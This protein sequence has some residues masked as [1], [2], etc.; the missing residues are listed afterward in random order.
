MLHKLGRRH[1]SRFGSQR[2]IL[3]ST[4]GDSPRSLSSHSPRSDYSQYTRLAWL[5]SADPSSAFSR[6]LADQQAVQQLEALRTMPAWLDD[7]LNPKVSALTSLQ[8]LTSFLSASWGFQIPNSYWNQAEH[9]NT[10]SRPGHK[11]SL[12][13]PVGS[14]SSRSHGPSRT[15]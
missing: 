8:F 4:Q 10:L 15:R 11:R 13:S 14:R 3:R 1:K 6:L 2:C 5:E 9:L 7:P 12:N